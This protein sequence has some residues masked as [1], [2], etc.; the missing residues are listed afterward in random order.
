MSL[1]DS[2]L[3]TRQTDEMVVCSEL[4]QWIN[5]E[6]QITPQI[7]SIDYLLYINLVF[8]NICSHINKWEICFSKHTHINLNNIHVSLATVSDSYI[9]KLKVVFY[10]EEQRFEHLFDIV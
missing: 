10:I 8:H 7:R 5:K 4:Q 3:S 9:Q 1:F 2:D 6:I